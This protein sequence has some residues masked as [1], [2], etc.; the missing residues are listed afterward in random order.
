MSLDVNV[1]EAASIKTK[2]TAI[3]ESRIFIIS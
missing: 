3:I 2:Q 1:V